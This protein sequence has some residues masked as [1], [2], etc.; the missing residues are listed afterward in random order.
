MT[1][2]QLEAFARGS[3]PEIHSLTQRFGSPQIRNVATLVGNIAHGSPVA[4][5][6]CFLAIVA[7]ELELISIRGSR[8]VAIKDF[9]TGPKQTVVAP[10]EIITRVLIPLTGPDEIVKLYKISKRKEMDVSTFRA[11]I[12]VRRQRRTD[13][14]GRDRLLRRRADGAPAAS[15]GGVSGRAAV[16]GRDLSRGGSARSCRGRADH[17]RPRLA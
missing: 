11:G 12:R 13:R 14:V 6:L 4:D 7:A 3:M 1:W 2:A 9:H 15:Y 16:L 5:S 8:R 10:D 17:R